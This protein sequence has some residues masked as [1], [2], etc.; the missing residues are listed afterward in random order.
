MSKNPE[1][2]EILKQLFREGITSKEEVDE[3]MLRYYVYGSTDKVEN[4][5][6]VKRVMEKQTVKKSFPVAFI[7]ASINHITKCDSCC[8]YYSS[9]KET[10]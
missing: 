3:A 8:K 1:N 9:L 4:C 10:S 2:E 6:L 5:D 7:L